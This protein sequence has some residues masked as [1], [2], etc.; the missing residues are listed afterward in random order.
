MKIFLTGASG[1]IGG[2]L[3]LALLS[4][5]HEVRGLTRSEKS[6]NELK[7]LGIF[8][9]LG[10][11]DNLDILKSEAF[12][13]DAVIN[14]ANADHLEAVLAMLD[15]LTGKHQKFIHTSGSS[16][17]GDDA[18][19]NQLSPSIFTDDTA[20][21]V[22]ARKQ[23]RRNIDLKVLEAASA[24]IQSCV[25]IPSLIYGYGLGIQ[26]NSIQVPFLVRNAIENDA[27][28]I[29]GQGLNAW[30][31][32][33]IEDLVDLYMLALEKAPAGSSYFAENGEATFREIAESISTRLNIPSID[34]LPAEIAAD[35]WGMARALFSLGSNSRVRSVR[36]RSELNW[37]PKHTSVQAWILEEMRG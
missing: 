9:V 13:A 18:R 12:Q 14:T 30:S 1:Y 7:A 20:L 22:D 11:L 23:A 25:I 15:G 35:R 29:V 6:A 21:L 24:G 8:P 32:V 34:H 31:N 5:G 37:K 10:D 2:S 16:I 28:Q 3:A 19:G 4:K 27:V 36:A 26:K 17:I 33:H